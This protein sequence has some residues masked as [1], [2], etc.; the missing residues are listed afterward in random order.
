M[1]D[2]G[3]P[4]WLREAI[5]RLAEA[6]GVGVLETLVRLLTDSVQR[7]EL[8]RQHG[9]QG[10]AVRSARM[11]PEERQACARKAARARWDRRRAQ[12]GMRHE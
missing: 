12:E 8:A 3:L 2:L 11:S 9:R 7:V 5:E 4:V 6:R 10:P 1:R